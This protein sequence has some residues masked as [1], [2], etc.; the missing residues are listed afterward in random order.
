MPIESMLVY[1]VTNIDPFRVAEWVNISDGVH[2]CDRAAR[3][4]D[5]AGIFNEAIDVEKKR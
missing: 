1:P 5:C 4:Q 2:Q 3:V